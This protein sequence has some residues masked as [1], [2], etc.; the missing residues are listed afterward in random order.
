MLS[1]SFQVEPTNHFQTISPPSIVSS[2]AVL[3]SFWV[4]AFN[5]RNATGAVMLYLAE[6]YLFLTASLE[7]S[8]A[9]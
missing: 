6:K 9:N 7:E 8:P 4:Q 5:V 1:N 3:T 2:Q